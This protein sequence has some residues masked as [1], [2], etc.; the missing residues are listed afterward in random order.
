MVPAAF[1]DTAWAAQPDSLIASMGEVG[2]Q[3]AQVEGGV[4]HVLDV[5]II[6]VCQ[7]FLPRVVESY[8]STK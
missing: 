3:L 4:P 8:A 6:W 1:M 2:G 5:H 7:R